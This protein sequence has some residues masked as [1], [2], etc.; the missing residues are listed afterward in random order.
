MADLKLTDRVISALSCPPGRRDVLFF[1]RDLPGFGLRVTDRGTRTF[2]YQYRYGRLIR[3][4]RLG[5]WGEAGCTAA[6]ARAEAEI[7][8]GRVRAGGDPFGERR[9]AREAA[10]EREAEARRKAAETAFTFGLLVER[11]HDVGI[12]HRRPRYRTDAKNRLLNYFDKWR[13]RPACEITRSEVV[14]ALDIVQAERGTT[15]ARRAKAYAHA[16][17]NWA[18]RRDALPANPFAQVAAP[19]AET[20]RDRVLEDHEIGAIWRASDSLSVR[21]RAFVRLL[22]LTLQRREEVGGMKWSELSADG[23]EWTVPKGR[24]KNGRAH[25]VH[26]AP[27]ARAVLQELPRRPGCPY[28]FPGPSGSL[29]TFGGIKSALDRTIRAE[30]LKTDPNVPAWPT[31]RFHDVRRSGVTT[32]ARMGFAPHVADRLLN[33]LTGAIQGVA[34]VYQRHEFHAERKAALEAWAA[35]AEACARNEPVPSNV[36]KLRRA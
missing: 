14:R 31:W 4:G 12:A 27:A 19:G 26:L 13:D 28:V 15:S 36:H 35:H 24:A 21:D 10:A 11:W 2:M 16:A 22:L 8:R 3:R 1:D 29:T 23:S 7:L 5:V 6:K 34:A 32:L 9:Q 17:Y 30:Q 33:H 18:C 25:V 20:P